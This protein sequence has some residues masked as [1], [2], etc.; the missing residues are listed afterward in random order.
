MRDYFRRRYSP[1]NITL[2]G[3]GR[4]R[5]RR[6]RCAAAER[7]VRRVAAGGHGRELPPAAA[8]CGLRVHHKESATLEYVV[9]L[10]NGPDGRDA[11]RFA[12]KML[13]TVLGDDSGSRLYWE[14]VDSGL[15]EQASLSHYDYQGTGLFMTYMSCEAENWPS[16]TWR[17]L[18]TSIARP[19]PTA[20]PPPS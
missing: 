12:A 14:L 4:D 5:F 19:R 16:R 1:G 11:D 15:A 17:A 8:A 20:S 9:Q 3:S 18:R 7:P 2:V 6:V 13:A 10:A